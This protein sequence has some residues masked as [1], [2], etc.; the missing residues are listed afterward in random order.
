MIKIKINS[1]NVKKG[2]IFLAIKGINS[3]GHDYIE[4][5]IKNG[6]E[7]IICEKGK[8]SV[9]TT[10]VRNTRK[11]LVRYLK[12]NYYDEIKDI[13]LIGITGTSG[14]TT[15]AFLTY[16][17]LKSFGENVAYIGTN[18][19]YIKGFVKSIDN[20]TP[21]IYELYELLLFCK[22]ENVKI[23]VMEISSHAL[24]LKRLES[25]YF[26]IACFTNLSSEHMDFHKNMRNYF[27]SKKKLFKLLRNDKIAIINEGKYS[28]KLMRIKNKNILVKKS[29]ITNIKYFINKT[30]FYFKSEKYIIPLVGYYNIL[31]YLDA[32]LI[33]NSLGYKI[34]DIKKI[35]VNAPIGRMEMIEYK[36]NVIFIDYAHK[37]DAVSK[38]LDLANE[39]KEE[40][41]YVVIGCGGD[42]DKTKRP[43][44]GKISTDLSDFVVFTNDN[45]RTEKAEDI[46]SDIIRNLKNDNFKIIKDRKKAI[47]YAMNLLS[48][49]DILLILGKGHENY[50]I[51]GKT[52]KYFSD[53]EIV[54]SQINFD[55]K[56]V[57]IK[58]NI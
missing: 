51:I 40:K 16:E 5:A 36:N 57:D 35:Q 48:N 41:I 21:D 52:K 26:D 50:Q 38:V 4:D 30:E 28:K 24:K 10:K 18:G 11:Y 23:V 53:K 37:P 8:Y 31:N 58:K 1:K 6:A 12:D 19:F 17:L 25:L 22:N 33:V 13:K 27:N 7:E 14:K 15:T 49:K 47:L 20:T 29:D 34:K 45:P 43:V 56:N 9:K 46:L 42:R 2:D 3:D 39:I 32:L 54:L 55:L 44:M